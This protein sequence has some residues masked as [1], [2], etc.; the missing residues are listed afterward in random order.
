MKPSKYTGNRM[1]HRS[2]ASG[3]TLIELMIVVAILG[4]LSVVAIPAFVRYMR[5][6]KTAEVYRNINKMT[7]GAIVY[8]TQ[9]K[10]DEAGQRIACMFPSGT[11]IIEPNLCCTDG[12]PDGKCEPNEAYWDAREWQALM[13]K[14][15]DKHYYRY[16]HGSDPDWGMPNARTRIT[17]GAMGDLDCD[18]TYSTFF[19]QLLGTYP[20]GQPTVNCNVTQR[21]IIIFNETE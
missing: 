2:G 6:A 16:A 11:D 1:Q 20:A 10:F 15:S 21:P 3:F 9:P 8:F 7:Q 17:L 14:L 13:F 12:E 5:I 4:I 19:R 18:G